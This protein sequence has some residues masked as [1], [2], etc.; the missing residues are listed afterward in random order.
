MED[1][2]GR[3]KYP[4][5]F[6]PAPKGSGSSEAAAR[7]ICLGHGLKRRSLALV[8]AQLREDL[9]G[10]SDGCVDFFVG[11]P[12]G[13]TWCS[14][15]F[16]VSSRVGPFLFVDPQNNGDVQFGPVCFLVGIQNGGF[17]FGSPLKQPEKSY[18][19]EKKSNKQEKTTIPTESKTELQK[20]LDTISNG[21]IPGVL[22]GSKL[23]GSQPPRNKNK[24]QA[25]DVQGP[26]IDL[27]EDF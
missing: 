7:L 27:E 23:F 15:L 3:T 19:L 11:I 25:C 21:T 6:R 24:S 9:D 22:Q 10:L 18:T 16:F 13:S 4:R 14:C 1:Q 20:G 17:L 12:N 2:P 8:V 26:G 5:A